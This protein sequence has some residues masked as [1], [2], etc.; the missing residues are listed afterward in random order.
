MK[1][2]FNQLSLVCMSLSLSYLLSSPLF[3]GQSQPMKIIDLSQNYWGDFGILPKTE[4][5]TSK[6][7]EK[8]PETLN[9]DEELALIQAVKSH[10]DNE[11]RFEAL[12]KSK[13]QPN[14]GTLKPKLIRF[15]ESL[16]PPTT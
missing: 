13:R 6:A 11:K 2:F 16:P 1:C 5:A 4:R 12:R 10:L 8:K 9:V 3:A 7:E 14:N 15:K